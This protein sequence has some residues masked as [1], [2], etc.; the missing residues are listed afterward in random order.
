MEC[1]HL[2]DGEATLAASATRQIRGGEKTVQFASDGTALLANQVVTGRELRMLRRVT[3]DSEEVEF[4]T[5]GKDGSSG[6]RVLAVCTDLRFIQL[7][8]RLFSI[9]ATDWNYDGLRRPTY[10]VARGVGTVRAD[11]KNGGVHVGG[12]TEESA[13]NLYN[14]L[15]AHLPDESALR[16]V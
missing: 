4:V 12:L 13:R 10:A 14:A 9:R 2:V 7:R 6:A 8:R 11:G 5:R 15:E 16:R 3:G 1:L